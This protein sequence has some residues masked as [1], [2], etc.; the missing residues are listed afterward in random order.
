MS[1]EFPSVYAHHQDGKVH[2][3]VSM[4]TEGDE[5]VHT[6]IPDHTSGSSLP[7]ILLRGFHQLWMVS[8]LHCGATIAFFFNRMYLHMGAMVAFSHFCMSSVDW[9]HY[10]NHTAN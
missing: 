10:T 3:C 4:L 9:V 6:V 8:R 5:S 1:G 2:L 7:L